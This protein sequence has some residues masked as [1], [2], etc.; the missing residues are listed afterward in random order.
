MPSP[1][2]ALDTNVLLDYA[3]KQVRVVKCFEVISKELRDSPIYVLPTVIDELNNHR[4]A[5]GKERAL[6]VAALTNILRWGFKPISVL[7]VGNGII[8]ATARKIRDAG[9]VPQ[10]EINDSYIIAEAALA[11]V[12]ILIS[13]DSHLKDIDHAKLREILEDCDLANTTIVP[14]GSFPRLFGH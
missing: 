14:P 5:A 8:E 7:P 12:G 1:Q 11:N 6:A 3:D 13:S 9:L 2:I 4:K 10:E